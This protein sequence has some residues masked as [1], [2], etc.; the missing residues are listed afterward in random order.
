MENLKKRNRNSLS[1]PKPKSKQEQQEQVEKLLANEND[2]DDFSDDDLPYGGKVYL[3]RR[4][5][6]D[7]WACIAFQVIFYSKI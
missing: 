7:S 3:A 5:K 1:I 4:Q 2:D 6:P